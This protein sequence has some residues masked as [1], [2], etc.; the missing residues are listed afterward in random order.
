MSRRD[1]A[2]SSCIEWKFGFGG[3]NYYI[4]RFPLGDVRNQRSIKAPYG[5]SANLAA[6]R[7]CAPQSAPGRAACSK[8]GWR[9]RGKESLS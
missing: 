9:K 6:A 2:E 3:E 1:V 8:L 4:V 5:F 7:P